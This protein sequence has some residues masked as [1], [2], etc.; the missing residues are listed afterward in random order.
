MRLIDF[1]LSLFGFNRQKETKDAPMPNPEPSAAQEPEPEPKKGNDPGTEQGN[2]NVQ[3]TSD[4]L[5]YEFLLEQGFQ[6]HFNEHGDIVF[7][8]QMCTFIYFS[9]HQDDLYF[10]LALPFVNEFS[11]ETRPVILAAAN[12][13][14]C[15]VKCAKFVVTDDDVWITV[16][17]LLDSTPKLEDFVPRLMDLLL[18]VR[19]AFYDE[20]K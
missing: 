8:Y 10:R 7:K 20:L 1:I 16:D 11:E 14:N 6:P 12:K 19:Q 13:M 15:L 17:S 4:K 2:N 3:S 18:R 9:S 5:M